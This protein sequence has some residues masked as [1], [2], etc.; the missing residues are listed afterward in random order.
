[1]QTAFGTRALLCTASKRL[2][3]LEMCMI[4]A[5]LCEERVN[6]EY[7]FGGG[8]QAMRHEAVIAQFGLHPVQKLEMGST[9]VSQADFMEF[10]RSIRC[11][12]S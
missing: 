2:F 6:R 7:F 3:L 5:K 4:C 9:D 11:V 12:T 8:I 1:M 10:L